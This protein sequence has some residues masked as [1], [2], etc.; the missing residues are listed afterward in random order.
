MSQYKKKHSPTHTYPDRQLSFVS[1]LHLLPSIASSCSIYMPDSLSAQPLSV[2]FGLPFSLVPST[3][4]SI[5]FFIQSSFFATHA[6]TIANCLAVLPRLCHL[7]L[8][9]LLILYLEV[10]NSV[11]Y[12]NVTHPSD[13]SHFCLLKCHLI[14]FPYGPGHTSMQHTTSHTT[15]PIY[16]VFSCPPKS[17]FF[18]DL[19]LLLVMSLYN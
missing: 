16:G 12:L 3:S 18:C 6:H 11:F 14:F 13:H 2:I 1:F 5:C 8:L 15:I 9:C 17:A 7:F 10:W 4:Y 19:L